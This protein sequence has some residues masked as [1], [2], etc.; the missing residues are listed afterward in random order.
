MIIFL[1]KT[2]ITFFQCKDVRYRLVDAEAFMSISDRSY[3]LRKDCVETVVYLLP[4]NN[5]NRA[6]VMICRAFISYLRS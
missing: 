5:L 3:F 4:K 2:F 6:D 1:L